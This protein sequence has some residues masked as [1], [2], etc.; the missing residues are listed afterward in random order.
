MDKNFGLA[1]GFAVKDGYIVEVGD[2]KN[3]ENKY[4]A[5]QRLDAHG[6]FIFPGFIDAHAHFIQYGL[7][8]QEADLVGTKSWEEVL[9]KLKL[10]ASRKKEGWLIGHGWDQNDWANKSFPDN[11]K[12]SRLFPDRPVLLT[13]ID[14]HA[15]IINKKAIDAAGI[16]NKWTINRYFD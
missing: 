1:Q 13:R 15:V 8:L 12:L 4:S 3:L 14:G 9:S 11:E 10:F 2:T 16:S 6:N 7:T 5:N